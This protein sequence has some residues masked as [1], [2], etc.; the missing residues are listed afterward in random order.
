M[1]PKNKTSAAKSAKSAKASKTA[2]SRKKAGSSKKAPSAKKTSL[3]KK[4]GKRGGQANRRRRIKVAPVTRRYVIVRASRTN[5]TLL[6]NLTSNGKPR[7][8][9]AADQIWIEDAAGNIRVESLPYDLQTGET[10][11]T[12]NPSD[13]PN[14]PGTLPEVESFQV[15]C[16]ESDGGY[17]ENAILYDFF[18]DYIS[19]D[20][21]L[22]D[23]ILEEPDPA[24]SN[25]DPY[26]CEDGNF[27]IGIEG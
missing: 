27:S 19:F 5:L 7:V 9:I 4:G 11:R 21:S 18:E 10:I 14:L 6:P 25:T 26:T 2:K 22:F 1:K 23:D 8:N 3:S 12:Y 13:D 16:Y 15:D 17:Y 20:L 24:T